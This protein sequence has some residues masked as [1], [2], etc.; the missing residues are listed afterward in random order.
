M[1]TPQCLSFPTCRGISNMALPFPTCQVPS[2]FP[3]ELKPPTFCQEPAGNKQWKDANGYL[4]RDSSRGKGRPSCA[5]A[6]PHL[7]KLRHAALKCSP[8]RHLC[9]LPQSAGA[10]GADG[11]GDEEAVPPPV[12]HLPHLPAAAGWA[13]LLPERRAS[14]V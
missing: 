11:G 2:T 5:Q 12:L 14:H 4:E 3:V 10:P 7:G 13:A 9:L 1:Q 6:H 8:C